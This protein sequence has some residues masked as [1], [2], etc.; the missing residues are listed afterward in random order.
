MYYVCIARLI[1]QGRLAVMEL[2]PNSSITGRG[3]FLRSKRERVRGV[4]MLGCDIER[5]NGS[6][7]NDVID[8]GTLLRKGRIVT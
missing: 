5:D 4:C 8:L 6:E 1:N 7:E 2:S 3:G